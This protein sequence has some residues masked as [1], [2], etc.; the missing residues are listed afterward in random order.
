MADDAAR[1][2][3]IDVGCAAAMN[4]VSQAPLTGVSEV[5]GSGSGTCEPAMQSPSPFQPDGVGGAELFADPEAYTPGYHHARARELERRAG[6]VSNAALADAMRWI[7]RRHDA[8]ALALAAAARP[9]S[10]AVA[11]ASSAASRAFARRSLTARS[12]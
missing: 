6:A 9:A 11:P 10:G 4:D 12:A 2:L 7:A 3:A 8:T 1:H 5:R